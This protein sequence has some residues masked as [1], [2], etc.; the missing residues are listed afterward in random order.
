M[1]SFLGLLVATA[2]NGQQNGQTLKINI[3]NDREILKTE[4]HIP[5]LR[6]AMTHK[7][8]HVHSNEYAV[9]F[10]HGAS[11]P[12]ALAFDFPM[13][14]YSWMDNLVENGYE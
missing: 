7:A 4:S 10:L 13:N 5:G 12:A 2:I 14:N 6:I 3:M 9:L 8:P 1:F 11:F